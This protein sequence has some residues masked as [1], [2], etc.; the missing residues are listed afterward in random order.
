MV[1]ERAVNIQHSRERHRERDT[2]REKE[3]G[4]QRERS[5]FST[6]LKCNY[7]SFGARKY[8]LGFPFKVNMYSF[9]SL[10]F[11]TVNFQ[12]IK[13]IFNVWPFFKQ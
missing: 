11:K 7:G 2:H 10:F 9:Y 8:L 5:N 1:P 6:R 12:L 3:R 4:R 13:F